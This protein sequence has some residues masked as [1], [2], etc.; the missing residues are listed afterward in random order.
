[1]AAPVGQAPVAEWSNVFA[2]EFLLPGNYYAC[3]V[4]PNNASELSYINAYVPSFKVECPAEN[5]EVEV[6][7][8]TLPDED[9]MQV[10]LKLDGIF[11]L[12]GAKA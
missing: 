1:M 11:F 7:L 6:A 2:P 8:T 9:Y 4:S 5:S 12:A 10:P 3:V